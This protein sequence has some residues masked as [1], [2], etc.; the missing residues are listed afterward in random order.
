MTEVVIAYAG[1][2]NMGGYGD[3]YPFRP[4]LWARRGEIDVLRAWI[5]LDG[6]VGEIIQVRLQQL[7]FT[8]PDVMIRKAM[9]RYGIQRFEPVIR[10]LLVS[11]S[12]SGVVSPTWTLGRDEI[13]ILL[14]LATAK[15]CEYQAK[16]RRDLFCTIPADNDSTAGVL[17]GG[18]SVAPTSRSICNQCDLPDTDYICS[19]L[20]HPATVGLQTMGGYS[21]HVGQVLCDL[22]REEAGDHASC[23]IG[24]HQCA[25]RLLEFESVSTAPQLSALGVPEAFDV[26]DAHWRL[27]FGK[28]RRLVTLSTV[29]GP[30]TLSL[31]CSNRTEFESR[32]SAIADVIDRLTVDDDLLPASLSDQQRVGSLNRLEAT[33]KDKLPAQQ[34][35]PI[36]Q[37]I[38]TLRRVRRVRNAAQHGMAEG[39][40]TES[41]VVL[42]ITTAPP[43]WA[44]A[45]DAIR[46]LTVDALTVIWQELRRWIDA[47]GA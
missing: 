23:H 4:C 8:D 14:H 21:R 17:T 39:G 20:L 15:D 6:M 32:L 47:D 11:E 43:D 10:E 29:T 44:T 40:L 19:H 31:G 18:S 22:G 12:T 3:K 37:A 13:P 24:G 2:A 9:I 26:L 7:G 5:E 28:T 46:S 38:M 42:G 45:W 36:G 25:Q 27:A 16:I 34:M 35:S 33:L 30:S 1:E 41:L